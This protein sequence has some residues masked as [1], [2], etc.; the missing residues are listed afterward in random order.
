[1]LESIQSPQDLHKLDYNQL[2]A[3]AQ[4]IRDKI[5]ATVTHTGGHL[6]AN[7]GVVELTIAL[8]SVLNSPED[9]IIW[10]VGHQCYPHKLLTNR[11]HKFDTLRQF[12]GIS[13]FPVPEESPHDIFRVGHSS[14]SISAALG[15]AK[16]RDLNGEDFNVVAVIGDGALTGGMAFEALNHAG[17]LGIDLVVFLNDNAMSIAKNVGALSNYLN[18]IRLDPALHKARA[19]L[20]NFIK[21]IP[22]IG[23]SVSR[24]GSSLKDAVKSLL[25][26]QLFEELG[27]S[28]FGPFDGHNIRQLQR[29]L[30]DGI[31][32]GGPVLI[33]AI[34]QKGKG[35]IPA[36]KN[37]V[38]YHGLGPN[39]G[40][41]GHENEN[42]QSVSFSAVFGTTLVELARSEP[43]ITAITAAM[44]DGTGLTEFANTFPER[45]FDVGIA[46]QHALTFAAGLA[47]QGMRPVVAIYS[48]FLQRGY[49]QILHDICLQDLPVVLA[50]DRSGIVGEDGPTHHGVFD[51]SYLSHM[52][53]LILLA[54]RNGAELEAML[55]WALAQDH[56]VAI[57]YPRRETK[58]DSSL[59]FD[60]TRMID[61]EILVEG[62][63]CVIL[64]VGTLAHTAVE[65]AA[66]LQPDITCRVVNMRLL[67]PIHGKDL[68]H[69]AQGTDLVFTLED[70]VAAGG[71]GSSVAK[72]YAAAGQKRV[73]TF[74]YPDQFIPQGRIDELHD[75]YGLTPAKIA[76]AIRQHL[77]AHLE[78][79]RS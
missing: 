20:E 1:M 77:H 12:G 19:E 41:S 7:L 16:A 31:K 68:D 30:R 49:D 78:Y 25:P 76:D 62:A 28:Y 58:V 24:L 37:P 67:K 75:L 72:F 27:F 15:I 44:P 22:A 61:S 14:T 69:L 51:L 17:Q 42:D 54:P 38:Q 53:N 48:T 26:G 4:E 3:L 21:K 55:K 79:R 29:A 64:A 8:H 35:F 5:I 11:Y 2:T 60:P 74:G 50:V 47:V 56:P 10:D 46:E 13:G 39:Y 57:R 9:K 45:F 33:H 18:K 6:G 23:G 52:P 73:V 66:L 70:N 40:N 43:K 71:F 32:R 63:D 65:A 59:V 36:E 34:T